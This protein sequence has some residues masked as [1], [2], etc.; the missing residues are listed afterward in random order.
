MAK[1]IPD[2]F[3]TITPH[4]VCKDALKAIEFYKKAFSAE[5]INLMP[6]PGGQGVMHAMLKI[7]NSFL[8][9]CDEFPGCD[10]FVSPASVGNKT[11]VTIHIYV[12]DVDKAHKQ[13]VD[14]G[15]TATMP[16]MDMFWGDRYGKVRDPEGHEWSIATHTRDMTE[17]EMA[18]EMEK[19]FAGG[20]G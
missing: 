5:Q 10:G 17:A 14:A 4:L 15:A 8:M 16:P 20:C 11:T 2:G 6:G 19:M 13:A 18:A 9:L 12:E 3:T 1:A 7:G